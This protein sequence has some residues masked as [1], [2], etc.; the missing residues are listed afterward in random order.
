MNNQF[1]LLKEMSS[2]RGAKLP[3]F[4]A[5]ILC[6][7]NVSV[8]WLVD[9]TGYSEKPVSEALRWLCD[10]ERGLVVRSGHSG[11]MIASDVYQLPLYWNEEIEP[12]YPSPTFD[13]GQ[14]PG[15]DNMGQKIFGQKNRTGKFPGLEA[16]I[17]ALE[18]EVFRLKALEAEVASLK[19]KI[20]GDQAVIS[21]QWP[22][23]SNQISDDYQAIFGPET[24]EIPALTV[25]NA[26]SCKRSS[27]DYETGDFPGLTGNIT[28]QDSKGIEQKIITHSENIPETGDFPVETG[29]I[30][31]ETGDFPHLI[32]S[33]NELISTDYK[34]VYLLFDS[35]TKT[36]DFPASAGENPVSAID[37]W[38]TCTDQ[39]KGSM[40]K[41]TYSTLLANAELLGCVNGH[42]T[43]RMQNSFC[44]D[45][46]EKRLTG[47]I[48]KMLSAMANTPQSVSFVCDGSPSAVF[49][50]L[51]EQKETAKRLL[52]EAEEKER[53]AEWEKSHLAIPEN[54]D[55][56]TKE[57]IEIC[58]DYLDHGQGMKFS[59]DELRELVVMNPDPEV[60]RFV[61]PR[62][63]TPEAA[64]R[65]ASRD[66]R[67]LKYFLMKEVFNI[68]M[69]ALKDFTN[70]EKISPY[71]IDY[72]YW[73]WYLED[74]I[75]NPDHKAGWY[76]DLI[77]KGS[78][79][80]IAEES[81]PLQYEYLG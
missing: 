29:N 19:E 44:R 10:P 9:K 67:H 22:A 56:Q 54:P 11:F 49:D 7:Q 37:A 33:K 70:D 35:E 40:D 55:F 24:G 5:L 18:S 63:K 28:G 32:N 6:R 81:K 71:L 43:I 42:Y 13:Q 59:V 73:K 62:A 41:Q 26:V 2:M 80:M 60:L 34:H 78:E 12:A 20:A 77:R 17:S 39:L 58:N 52:L 68:F 16:R 21:G 61:L 4:I 65:W 72:H 76:V 3:V 50:P 74:R 79:K 8:K 36:G 45:W 46:A 38:R 1:N 23:A 14:L 64:R 66:M 47:T 25:G 27:N 48:E 53:Q 30:L 15:F 57:N 75:E 51:K 31:P 69:P